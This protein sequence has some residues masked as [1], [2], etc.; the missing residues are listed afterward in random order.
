MSENWL[1][2]PK[3][4]D[5]ARASEGWPAPNAYGIAVQNPHVCFRDPDL[6]AA[7]VAR[8]TVTRMPK[9][10][11][12]N[13]AQVY[14]LQ[15]PGGRW[16]VKCFTRSVADIRARYSAIAAAI[17]RSRLPYFV[18]FEFLDGEMLVDGARWPVLKMRWTDGQ[19]LDRFV[20]SNLARPRALLAAASQLFDLVRA[21]E[22]KKL[23]HGDLQH[24]N[25][26]VQESGV[27]LVDYDGMFV[28]AFAGT[29]SPEI[30]AP[31]YQ[32]PQRSNGDYAVGLDRFS[33]LAIGTA[34][35]AVAVDPSVWAEFHT[36]DN[37]I[38]TG[39]DFRNPAGS[40]VLDRL[41]TL[42]DPQLQSLVEGLVAA[43]A[44]RPLEVSLPAR[45]ISLKPIARHGFWWVPASTADSP[46][47]PPSRPTPTEIV[48]ARVNSALSGLGGV[49]RRT[50]SQRFRIRILVRRG[51]GLTAETAELAEESARHGRLPS[52]GVRGLRG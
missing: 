44:A 23:A 46:P 31:S 5:G 24:G 41:R 34:L 20:A 25:I 27:R 32:H 16:A 11:T 33:A 6:K 19:P 40:R 29:A 17:S 37:L 18:D 2:R 49:V 10:W 14:E 42:A 45:P 26:I 39:E 47:P 4:A 1:A 3:L 30:G 13:F 50:L 12:G 36:G 7:A 38:F 15:A 9:V 22:R 51:R 8:T 21:L 52:C 43:C 28:P 48:T 35:A